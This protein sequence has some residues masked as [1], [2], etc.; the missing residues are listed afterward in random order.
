MYK[1]YIKTDPQSRI[2]S[3]NSDAFLTSTADWTQIDE[4]DGDR[5]HHAQGNYLPKSLTA[6][7]GIYRY[8]LV[9]G[10]VVER[11][12]AEIAADV[13]KIPPPPPSAEDRIR[14]L[15]AKLTALEPTIT[16]RARDTADLKLRMPVVKTL[17]GT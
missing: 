17:G 15:E 4:G 5:Y 6:E 13:A 3:V 9:D 2:T 1:V 11:T 8:K 10:K 12:A 14:A 7:Q 16:T